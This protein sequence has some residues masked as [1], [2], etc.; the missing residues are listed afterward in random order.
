[1]IMMR[2]ILRMSVSVTVITIGLILKV[3]KITS[4]AMKEVGGL[5]MAMGLIMFAVSFV[6][7]VKSWEKPK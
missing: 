6:Y 4:S 1:M 3:S 5:M 2:H 7:A